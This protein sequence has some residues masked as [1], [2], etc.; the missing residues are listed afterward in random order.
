MKNKTNQKIIGIIAKKK[1]KII[2]KIIK[3]I[4]VF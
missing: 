3:R 2:I 4:K 1:E